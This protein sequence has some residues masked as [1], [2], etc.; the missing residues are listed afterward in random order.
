MLRPLLYL[1]EVALIAA[2]AIFLV[3]H[4]G[5]VRFDWQ[6]W[7]IDTSLGVVA[8]AVGL[9]AVA[10]AL[11]LRFWHWLMH[12][13][14]EWRRR[15]R[16]R[17][18]G[19]GYEAL[20]RGMVAVAAGDPGEARRYA[21]RA[22]VLLHDPPLTLLL[23]AQAAQLEGDDAAAER[24]F[25]AM[26]ERPETEFLG[27]RGL[28][29]QALGKGERRRA[30]ALAERAYA[31]RPASP[32]LV[33]ALFELR[34]EAGEWQGAEALMLAATRT[35]SIPEAEAKRRRAVV[36]TERARQAAGAGD[37]RMAVKLA[38]Q[39]TRLE[40]GLVPAAVLLAGEFKKLGKKRRAA[41]V[42][43]SA[44]TALPHADLALAYAGLVE[45]SAPLARLRA[46]ERLAAIRPDHAEG[47]FAMAE[48]ALAAELWG[49][50]RRH[51]KSAGDAAGPSP[52]LCRLM[53]RLETDEHGN[54]AEARRWLERVATAEPDPDWVCE[55]CGAAAPS[56][57]AVCGHCRSIGRI[58]WKKPP[59]VHRLI[60]QETD[61]TQDRPDTPTPQP[62]PAIPPPVTAASGAVP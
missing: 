54:L 20:S 14:G 17:R 10:L 62:A 32:W 25:A 36:L 45:D 18:R 31:L 5:H 52:R 56:W 28:L 4:P 27:L 59:R 55:S 46:L 51:L 21:R 8:L 15:R 53:A 7:R 2:A 41:R 3:E 22:D 19:R 35:D 43:E 61:R 49:E 57:S 39:A 30:R 16:E 9:F 12:A 50:A 58:L 23:S 60:S 13:P 29:T 44:W 42:I 24:Y 26:R 34:A 37:A 47:H 33:E 48:A 6:D 11:T 40:P 1:L 38:K